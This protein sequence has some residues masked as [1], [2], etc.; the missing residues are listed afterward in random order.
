MK[1]QET[2]I[3]GS[4][5]IDIRRIEDQRGFFARTWCKNEFAEHGLSSDITQTNM[6]LSV[7][8][9]TLRGMHFQRSPHSEVKIV[10]CSAGAVFDVVLDL[11]PESPTYCQWFGLELNAENFRMLYIPTG[12]AHGYQT[13]RDNT[14]LNY[15]TSAAYAPNHATGVRFDDPTF[16]IEW[17]LQVNVISE[18]DVSWPD[19]SAVTGTEAGES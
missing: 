11:R 7:S 4:Y 12:C 16:A 9:G 15:A 8:A 14:V 19:F 17:P 5:V 3:A 10:S 13:I 6:A 18:A 2:K 1:F